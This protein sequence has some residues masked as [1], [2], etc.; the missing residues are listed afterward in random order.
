MVILSLYR[1]V[2]SP[3]IL[4]DLYISFRDAVFLT[5][6]KIDEKAINEVFKKVLDNYMKWCQYLRIRMAWNRYSPATWCYKVLCLFPLLTLFSS[7]SYYI[8]SPLVLTH[9]LGRGNFSW[10]PCTFLFGGRL[11]TFVFFLNA[12]ATYFTMYAS[13]Y[14]CIAY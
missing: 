11:P 8:F 4:I 9:S 3:I 12:F 6:Q 14:P 2:C 5:F 7:C 1:A 13:F 10:F